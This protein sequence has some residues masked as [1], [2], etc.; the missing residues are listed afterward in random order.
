MMRP[1]ASEPRTWAPFL[2]GL[3]AE[4]VVYPRA[5]MARGQLARDL[6]ADRA[7]ATQQRAPELP[8][9]RGTNPKPIASWRASIGKG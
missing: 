9:T 1:A 6:A 5:R 3:H 2:V 8:S 7:D 4:L